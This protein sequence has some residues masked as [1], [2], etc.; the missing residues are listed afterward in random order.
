M[1]GIIVVKADAPTAAT[2][3]V[4]GPLSVHRLNCVAKVNVYCPAVKLRYRRKFSAFKTIKMGFADA[5]RTLLLLVGITVS[6]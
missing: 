1:S 3:N 2:S 5:R 6:D 4:R